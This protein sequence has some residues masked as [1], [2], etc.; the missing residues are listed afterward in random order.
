MLIKV[1]Q[2]QVVGAYSLRLVFN[3]GKV[4]RVNLRHWLNGPVFTP[5]R[6]PAVFAQFTLD[7]E[8][9]TWPEFNADME[10][11]KIFGLT[12]RKAFKGKDQTV[13]KHISAQV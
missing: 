1:V 4:K 3:D 8:T 10:M 11:F 9:V 6:D 13:L 12:P 7:D 5:L 2:A